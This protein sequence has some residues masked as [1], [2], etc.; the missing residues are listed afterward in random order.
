MYCERLA[1]LSNNLDFDEARRRIL[2]K[3][4]GTAGSK[5]KVLR[6]ADQGRH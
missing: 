5:S 3:I 6:Q 2:A 1:D 4:N